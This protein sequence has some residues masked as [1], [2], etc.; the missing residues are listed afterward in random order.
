DRGAV[1]GAADSASTVVAL[2]PVGDGKQVTQGLARIQWSRRGNL[3]AGV[4]AAA[5]VLRQIAAKRLGGSTRIVVITNAATSGGVA[6][7]VAA[8][9]RAGARVSAVSY[10][11]GNGP[12]LDAI[13]HGSGS[14]IV[15]TSKQ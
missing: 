15:A 10:Q 3:R 12:V 1:I 8:L 11:S 4:R 9:V 7:D 6:K 14:A 13:A 2:Q 5:A